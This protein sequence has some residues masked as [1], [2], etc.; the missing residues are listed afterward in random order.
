MDP[1]P[2]TPISAEVYSVSRLAE[3]VRLLLDGAF[4]LLW[5]EGEIS[6][7]ARPRSGHVYFTLKDERAQV[8]C[9]LFRN[10]AQRLRFQPGHGERVLVR[11]R[12][13]LY[14]PRGDFQ[15]IVEHMEPAGHGA[16]QRA[17]EAL[18]ARLD[19]EGLFAVE[20]K[21]ALPALPRRLGVITSPTGA[22]L[23]DV[24]TVL[25]RRF[26]ALPVLIYP[27]PVQGEGAAEAIAAAI[28]RAGERAEVDALLI[29]RGGGSLEDLWAFNEEVVARAIHACPL[30]VVSAVGHEVDVSI[31]DLVA[32]QR[33]PTP[34]AAAELL[35]P[36]GEAWARQLEGTAQRLA[37]AQQRRL[38]DTRQRLET[39]ARRLQ[40]QHPGR[41]LQ[42]RAQRLDEIEQRLAHALRQR[43]AGAEAR[44]GH[45]Q[46]R[47]LALSPRQRIA[48][49][50]EHTLA[51][52]RRLAA[53]VQRD[54]ERRGA[55][56]GASAR[57]LEAV[58]PLATLGRGYAI[59]RRAEDDAILRRAGDVSIGEEVRA[60]LH[61]GSLRCRVEG[62]EAA[63][64]PRPG[65]DAPGN[66]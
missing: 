62:H 40:A 50:D 1:S 30:P 2:A 38:G 54:L 7:L 52:R 18:K 19:A 17:F 44:L 29:T 65:D 32:D 9:A 27:V 45:A 15:L 10:R 13:S 42:E 4:P 47:L 59:V 64:L 55:R 36:D 28:R 43:L 53:A 49:L 8:R 48:R 6:N 35:S 11:A 60:L 24:L 39:L 3:E 61:E 23:R 66:G 56:L 25:R 41:R 37:R 5:V 26:P 16:L 63:S 58:S 31:A 34:S 57:A 22:A 33:A 14:V 21:R 20:H 46:E 12:V 51:L